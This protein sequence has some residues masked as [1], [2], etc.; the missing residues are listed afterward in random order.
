MVNFESSKFVL[1]PRGT[2]R[3]AAPREIL[4][5]RLEAGITEDVCWAVGSAATMVSCNSS[6]SFPNP[7]S[8]HAFA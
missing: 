6:H 4:F 1:A 8:R 5:Y 2:A 7:H 3:M